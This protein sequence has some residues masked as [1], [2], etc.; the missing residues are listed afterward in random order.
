M[1]YEVRIN[2][3]ARNDLRSIY[4]YI[5]FHLQEPHAALRQYTKIKSSLLMLSEKP[6]RCPLYGDEPWRGMG[7]RRMVI[8]S[9]IAFYWVDDAESAVAVLRVMFG[10]R[11]A[12]RQLET[13]D[14]T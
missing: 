10:G 2:Q 14:L 7:L 12:E 8:G 11:D 5:A 13:I 1:G 3:Q 6:E 9:Y 4:R